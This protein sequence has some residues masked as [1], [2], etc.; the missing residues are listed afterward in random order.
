MAAT[1][2][3]PPGGRLQRIEQAREQA[4]HHGTALDPKLIEPWIAR[5]WQRCLALGLRPTQRVDFE[6]VSHPAMQRAEEENRTLVQAARPVLERLSRAMQDT[7]YFAILTN[8]QG[9]V[10]DAHGPIDHSDPRAHLITRIGTNLSEPAV[11][12][13]AIGAALSEMAPVWLHRGEHF[14]NDTSI[15]SCAGAPLFGP[16][17]QLVGMLDL[18]GVQAVERPELRHLVLQSARS[19]ENALTLQQGW[20]LLLRLNWPGQRL[21]DE[22]D[23]LIGLDADGA[24]ACANATARQLLPELH[25]LGVQAWH[26]RDLFALPFEKFFD[27]ARHET[28]PIEVPLWSGL[29]LQVL[30]RS[31]QR[32]TLTL[33]SEAARPGPDDKL[34]NPPLKELESAIIRQAVQDAKGNVAQA[35]RTLG[36]SRATVY[37]KIGLQAN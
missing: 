30:A 24:I 25:L 18:T 15:Y 12:T 33:A 10:V 31:R 36:I 29:R 6:A 19:I 26:C 5:S 22:S 17:G 21:E 7:R 23:G 34:Q 2:T 1:L 37:R 35:A 28:G 16:Q 4:L 14:F 9:T 32:A 3:S 8:Q 27:S 11:S 20:A 13:T